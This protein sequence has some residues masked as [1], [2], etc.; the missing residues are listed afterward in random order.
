MN[1]D[2]G[3]ARK[4][5]RFRARGPSG[6]GRAP[7]TNRVPRLNIGCAHPRPTLGSCVCPLE[8][9][10]RPGESFWSRVGLCPPRSRLRLSRRSKPPAG[11]RGPAVQAVASERRRIHK[12]RPLSP[13]AARTARAPRMRHCAHSR[14]WRPV[15]P[16][17]AHGYPSAHAPRACEHGVVNRRRCKKECMRPL[18]RSSSAARARQHDAGQP[19]RFL[20]TD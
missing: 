12:P 8:I 17:A 9:Y 6:G 3:Q 1:R 4:R 11:S 2:G 18:R 20:P 14:P 7:R 10:P 13:V 19:A 5:G 15:P 16:R